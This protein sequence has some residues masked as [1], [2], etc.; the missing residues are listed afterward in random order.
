MRK[1]KYS[2]VLEVVGRDRAVVTATRYGLDGPGIESRWGTKFFAP[3]QTGPGAKPASH[4]MG[5]VSFPEVKRPGSG[6]DHPPSSS[7]EVN[8]RVQLQFYFLSGLSW[9]VK[10]QQLTLPLMFWR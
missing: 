1:I 10:G 8:E 2:I 6:D 7:A 5:T 3:V 4:K 9:P